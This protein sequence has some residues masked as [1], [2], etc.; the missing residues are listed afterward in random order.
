MNAKSKLSAKSRRFIED[1]RVYLFSSGKYADEIDEIV[2]EL[3]VHLLEA[4]TNGKSIGKVVGRSPQEYMEQLSDEMPVDYKSWIKYIVIIILGAFSFTIANDLMEGTLSYSLL[5]LIGHV[6]IGGIFIAGTF[7]AF[8]YIAAN[9]LSK[10]KE[11]GVLSALAF[12]PLALFFGLIYLNRAVETPVIHFD[13]MGTVLTA[14]ITGV[15]LFGVSWWAKTWVVPIILALLIL[16]EPLLGMTAMDQKTMLVLSA[17]ISFG[18]V[19]IYLLI[20]SKMDKAS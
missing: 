16:P 1:L 13:T 12:V 19:G 20:V 9:Q 6:V 5:E 18:G 17:F 14:V 10:R 15:F 11:I 8:K 3:E 2:E 7:T 4:E